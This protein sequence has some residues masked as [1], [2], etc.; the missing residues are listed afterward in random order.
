VGLFVGARGARAEEGK[1][2]VEGVPGA[3]L[4]RV[5]AVARA[6][7]AK[8]AAGAFDVVTAQDPFETGLGALRGIRRARSS[9]ARRTPLH[10]QIHTDFLSPWYARE[11]WKNR[12][13]VRIAG[14]TL[15]QAAGIRVVSE[16]VKRSLVARYGAAIKEPAVIPIAVPMPKDPSAPLPAAPN[17]ATFSM[18][19]VGRLEPEKRIGDI[20]VALSRVRARYPKTALY[21]AGAG[22]E[23]ERLATQARALGLEGAVVWLGERA[24][25]VSLIGGASAFV[26]ASAYEGYGRT[27]VEAALM[28]A[29][30]VTTDVGIVGDVLKP[31]RDV[32]AVPVADPQA[33]AIALLRLIEDNTLREN[34]ASE[35][36][37]AARNHLMA[38]MDQPG[39]VVEDL[40][41]AVSYANP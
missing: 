29:P 38:N 21:V 41:R 3:R 27:L 8:L 24:D 13:R 9:A 11:S 30:I 14:K 12:L 26:Q 37:H 28:R 2:A 23:Q 36:A 33:I 5:R 7:R 4:L 17:G 18:L 16:R 25:A 35:A 40:A 6:V 15:P 19:A 31:D 20:L 22:R 10:L 34:L 1:L 32:L 39:E